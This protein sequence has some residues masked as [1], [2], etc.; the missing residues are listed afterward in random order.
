M[1]TGQF[2]EWHMHYL[3]LGDTGGPRFTI[4]VGPWTP[5]SL[6]LP[7]QNGNF[8]GLLGGFEVWLKLQNCKCLLKLRGDFSKKSHFEMSS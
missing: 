8:A 1:Q 3:R 6:F 2:G 7:L 5:L 4:W